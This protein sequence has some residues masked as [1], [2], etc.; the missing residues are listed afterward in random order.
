MAKKPSAIYEPGELEK[1]RG[2]LGPVDESE[3]KL[4]AKKLGGEIGTEKS[5]VTPPIKRPSYVRRGKTELAGSD[6]KNRR[7]ARQVNSAQNDYGRAHSGSKRD[8]SD[9]PSIQLKTSY[10][11]RVKMD[12]YAAQPEFEIKSPLQV[13]VSVICFFGEP[14]DNVN[15]RFINDRMS[16]YY[17][18]IELLVNATRALSPRNNA[19]RS[20]RLKKTSPYYFSIVEVLR[21]WD[22]ERINDELTKIRTSNRRINTIDFAEI[23]RNIY[24]PLFII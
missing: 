3:A 13:F 4:I 10:F 21:H 17:K 7:P 14:A 1:V 15:P 11:E 22:I 24:R 6:S 16:A 2:R 9:D 20:E 5:V 8:V 12:R 18:K 19:K 23:L